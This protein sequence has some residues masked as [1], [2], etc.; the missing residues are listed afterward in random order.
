MS[1]FNFHTYFAAL[2]HGRS[3]FPWQQLLFDNFFAGE[4]PNL[5]D[6]PTGTGKTSV[7]SIWLL[8]LAARHQINSPGPFPR[9]LVWVVDRRVVVDQVQGEA[10]RIQESLAEPA[11]KDIAEILRSMSVSGSDPAEPAIA[12][13]TL[14]GEFEDN[15]AWS[16]DPSRP[17]IIAGTVDMIG[18]RLLFSGYGVSWKTRAIQAA[19]LAQDS[20][21][22]NDEAH[23]TPAFAALIGQIEE[24]SG[25]HAPLRTILMTATPTAGNHKSSFPAS[26]D[27]DLANSTFALRVNAPKHL[28]L[29]EVADPLKEIKSIA[30]VPA[31]RTAVF[32][33]SPKHARDIAKTLPADS[34]VVI[35]GEMRG[36]ERNQVL[37]NPIVKRLGQ[38][39]SDNEMPC[40]IVATSA[41]EVGMDF[42]VQRLIT[43]LD[44]ADHLIQRFGRLNRFG[45]TQGQA[46]VVGAA[47]QRAANPLFEATWNYLQT[48]NANVSP[49]QLRALPPDAQK[50]MEPAP[51]CPPLLPW[52]TDVWSMTSIRQLDWP[53]R[54][55]VEPWLRGAEEKTTPETYVAWRDETA[56]LTNSAVPIADVQQALEAFPIQ[57]HEKLKQNTFELLPILEKEYDQE[58][59]VLQLADGEV[60][61]GTIGELRVQNPNPFPYSTLILPTY[62]GALDKHGMVEWTS[63]ARSNDNVP[64]RD[65]AN[66]EKRQKRKVDGDE[67][68][69]CNDFKQRF[70]L[71]VHESA[72]SETVHHSWF[73]WTAKPVRAGNDDKLKEL[74]PHLTDTEAVA[75][76]LAGC[77]NLAAI[78]PVIPQILAWS[79]KHHDLGKN[80]K[81]WQTVF[82]NGGYPEI[83]LAK[84]ASSYINGRALSGFRHELASL[85]DAEPHLPPEWTNEQRDLALHLIGC[86]HG[87]ARPHFPEKAVDRENVVKSQR[88]ARET[89]PR[90]SRLQR[91]WGPWTLA[92]LESV[93]R[94]ADAIASR[95]LEDKTPE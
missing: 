13:S 24:Q 5:I 44:S 9:R 77:L 11:N 79:A 18:S 45:V 73:F 56:D 89:A 91:D 78:H 47:K 61:R 21:I 68:D 62:I 58:R 10:R 59:V 75:N 4:I 22:V 48:L 94:A 87:F 93:L 28:E 32:V 83:V 31:G 6:L 90:F 51:P 57:S 41:A 49:Q 34:V 81:I 27:A 1:A 86:H 85:I 71:K 7:M 88:I 50:T 12:A 66:T 16:N 40:W 70:R 39:E 8:A 2:N 29:R 64:N 84:S 26:L 43:D 23:L 25:S 63:L 19:L 30:S 15:R 35:T 17:A 20:L 60:I 69:N 52:Q 53:D 76:Q 38:P 42:S 36:L 14:R 82:G 80:R 33:R 74:L 37:E 95:G 3:P 67:S 46:I 55:Q 92:Y 72:D 65:V 54:P